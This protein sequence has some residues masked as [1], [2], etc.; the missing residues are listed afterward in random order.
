VANTA[1]K[2]ADLLTRHDVNLMR[3]DA[4]LRRKIIN[5]LLG[6][7][8]DVV[9]KLSRINPSEPAHINFKLKRFEALMSATKNSYDSTYGTIGKTM[10]EQLTDLAEIESVNTVNTINKVI[11][12]RLAEPVIDT[13]VLKSLVGSALIEGAPSSHWWAEQKVSQR[14]AFERSMREGVLGGEPLGTLVRRVRGTRAA[15]FKDGIFNATR[16]QAEALVRSSV[17]AVANEARNKTYSDNRDVVKGKQWLSTLDSRTTD[18]CKALDGQAWDLEGRKLEGTTHNFVQPPPAHWNCRS[19]LV[20]VLKSWKEL[21]KSKN[22]K[23]QKVL[24][25]K[26]PSRRTRSEM[27]GLKIPST[28]TYDQWLQRKY[29]TNPEMVSEIL[30]PTKLKMWLQ[31]KIAF[32]DLIDQSWNPLTVAQLRNKV[33]MR[34]VVKKVLPPVPKPK[35]K[36]KP[37]VSLLPTKDSLIQAGEEHIPDHVSTVRSANVKHRKYTLDAKLLEAKLIDMRKEMDDR[38]GA[39]IQKRYHHTGT[40]E[41]QA[42][43]DAM[44]EVRS[45]MWELQGKAHSLTENLEELARNI[46]TGLIERISR[47]DADHIMRRYY[48]DK[49][50]PIAVKGYVREF[51]RMTGGKGREASSYIS[52][53]RRAYAMKA[54]GTVNVGNG[55]KNSIFHEMGHFVEFENDRYYRSARTFIEERAVGKKRLSDLIPGSGY[56]ADEVAFHDHFINP[57]VGKEYSGGRATEVISVGLEHFADSKSLSRLMAEDVDHFLLILGILVK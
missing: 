17:Q 42:A 11:Q 4:G 19:T 54:T 22:P 31:K 3:V 47:A 7:E 44:Q 24:R 48:F 12:V 13:N 20:P 38:F 50:V 56:T 51:I 34:A 8:Q 41:Y 18:I 32:T 10:R 52:V 30:G 46:R 21:S 43:M 2:V 57:Y 16:R 5:M 26:T 29:T 39:T 36:P 9:E 28:M 55:K 15:G 6:L 27:D 40:P 14:K 49:A 37:P 45:Q 25:E 35:P 33:G 53:Q 23:V 1:T